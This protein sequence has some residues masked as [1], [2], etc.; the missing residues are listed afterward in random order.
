MLFVLL[1]IVWIR[2]LQ[3]YTAFVASI[4]MRITLL[5]SDR[6]LMWHSRCSLM[7]MAIHLHRRTVLSLSDYG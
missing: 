2:R 4:W 7:C 6:R 5:L 3:D 1:V